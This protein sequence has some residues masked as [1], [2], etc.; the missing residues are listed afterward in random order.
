MQPQDSPSQKSAT[1]GVALAKEV[2][3]E[4][5]A[6]LAE[7]ESRLQGIAEELKKTQPLAA[8]AVTLHLYPCG[9]GCLGCPH[10]RWVKWYIGRHKTGGTAFMARDLDTKTDPALVLTRSK[11]FAPGYRA[12]LGLVREAKR[13]IAAKGRMIQLL[14]RLSKTGTRVEGDSA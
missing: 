3:T 6:H 8:G 9:P 7:I 5:V 4:T 12:T 14:S 2:L 10:P 13:L 11:D 1:Y